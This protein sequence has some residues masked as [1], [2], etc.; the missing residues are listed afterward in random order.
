MRTKLATAAVLAA[1]LTLGLTACGPETVN[2]KPSKTNA[3]KKNAG[4]SDDKADKAKQDK[5]KKDAVVGDTLTLH[6]TEDGSQLDVTLLKWADPAKGADEFNAPSDGKKWVAGQFRIVNT[7]SKVYSDSPGNCAQVADTKGQRFSTW[8]GEITAGPQMTSD[9]KLP[10][11]D[12]ALGWIL[13]EVP[14]GSTMKTVQ[15]TMESG[16]ASE[17]GQWNIK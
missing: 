6:G 7:G 14:K 5:P 11:G 1:T 9:L 3:A 10:K 2:T 17:T 13:F 12:K 4:S 8:F 16:F 15:F